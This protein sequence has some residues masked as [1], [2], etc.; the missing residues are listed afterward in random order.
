[1]E[2][3]LQK[4]DRSIRLN[5]WSR[6][7]RHLVYA[8]VDPTT[9]WDLGTLPVGPERTGARLEQEPFLHTASNESQGQFSPD[10]H[11]VA[12]TS[13][14]SGL[15]QIYV[16]SFPPGSGKFMISTGGATQPRWR[17]DGKELFYIAGNGKLMALDVKTAPTFEFGA[18][19]ALFD[20]RI[21]RTGE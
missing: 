9:K 20:S 1:N 3:L 16:Q 10:G 2:E 8:K 7:G 18:S 14:E 13:D 5:D 19:K 15:N 17:R 21:T 6:D 11:W 4:S 12:Y